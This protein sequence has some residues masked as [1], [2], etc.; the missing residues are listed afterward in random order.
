MRYAGDSV[1]IDISEARVDS[2]DDDEPSRPSPGPHRP[3]LRLRAE[4]LLLRLDARFRRNDFV[5]ASETVVIDTRRHRALLAAPVL[6]TVAG[7]VA[8]AAGLHLWPLIAFAV[9]SGVWA[10][11]RHSPGFKR[12]LLAAAAAPVALVVLFGLSGW[13]LCVGLLLLWLVEDVA[14]WASDRL[15]VSDKR[16]YRRYGIVTGHAPSMSL[17]AV[18]YLDAS[19]PPVGHLLGY[20]TLRLDSAAQ[21]DAPLS[22]FDQ[23]PD[24][25]GVSH[26]ILRLRT[27]AM[28]KYPL[29]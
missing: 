22:R 20:G 7:L 15:V 25:V 4:E 12:V 9:L 10:A 5:P 13:P 14:D 8:L 28:P 26:E 2:T 17:M 18:A 11:G 29:A 6:R 21:N 16:I 24:V 23:V 19:V 3:G 1:A 27:S